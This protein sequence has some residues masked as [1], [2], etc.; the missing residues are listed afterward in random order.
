MDRV[1][2]DSRQEIQKIIEKIAEDCKINFGKIEKI[3]LLDGL[4]GL[5]L[6]FFHYAESRKST[7]YRKVA[8]GVFQTILEKL[9]RQTQSKT[10]CSGLAGF[11][12]LALHLKKKGW[13]DIDPDIVL[14]DIDLLIIQSVQDNLNINFHDFLHGY[15]GQLHYLV[16][17][18]TEAKDSAT[19][20]ELRR[21][22]IEFRLQIL[23][24][25]ENLLTGVNWRSKSYDHLGYNFGLA[26]G[27]PGLISVLA[28]L[29]EIDNDLQ[30]HDIIYDAC[31]NLFSFINDSDVGS[32]FPNFITIDGIRSGK[33]RLGWC[34]G[35][36]GV[37]IS[38]LNVNKSIPGCVN[39]NQMGMIVSSILLRMDLPENGIRDA[40]ICHGTSG[41]AIFFNR[42]FRLHPLPEYRDS[43]HYWVNKTIDFEK[44]PIGLQSWFGSQG[45]TK[46]YGILEGISG[47][48]LTLLSAIDE[49]V[50]D[51]DNALLI[52][53]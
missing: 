33:S 26:H 20:T 24:K 42:L 39:D 30:T 45:Y 1:C 36:I 35:D 19:K 52:N 40:G 48:G 10:Y 51:W 27:T 21:L 47:I 49:N 7:Q 32:I 17:R 18:Y 50:N 4:S 46:E 44:S 3:G 9:Y 15:S 8:N 16:F 34:Y 25:S 23:K 14:K 53:Y 22:L 12:W 11:C 5:A 6:F 31:Q 2:F 37:F 43:A 28:S 13:L 38:L 29:Y 41:I